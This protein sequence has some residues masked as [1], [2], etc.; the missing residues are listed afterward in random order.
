[1]DLYLWLA[2]RYEH[3]FVDAAA[4]AEARVACR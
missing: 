1:M 3:A 4:V 2:Q